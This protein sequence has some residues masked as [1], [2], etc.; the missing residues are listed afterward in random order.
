MIIFIRLVY[1][2]ADKLLD[3]RFV[4]KLM[5]VRNQQSYAHSLLGCVPSLFLMYLLYAMKYML[6]RD[7]NIMSRCFVSLQ[8]VGKLQKKL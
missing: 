4:H 5:C 6:Y 8:M 2:R 1:I 3:H 7:Y